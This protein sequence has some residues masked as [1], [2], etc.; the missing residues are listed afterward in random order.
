MRGNTSSSVSAAT[1]LVVGTEEVHLHQVSR[2]MRKSIRAE[3]NEEPLGI[4]ISG[5]SRDEALPKFAAYVWG[6]APEGADTPESKAA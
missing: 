3:K 6:P 5:G 4:V 1:V 2:R